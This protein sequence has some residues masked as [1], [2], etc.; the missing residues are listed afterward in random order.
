MGLMET[1]QL[2]GNFGEFVGAIAV[3]LTLIYLA[4]QVGQSKKSIDENTRALDEN[5][6]FTREDMERQLVR[7]WDQTNY[8]LVEN[9]D[10]ASIVVRGY[11]DLES[12]DD[13]ER[14]IFSLRFGSRLNLHYASMRLA[15]DG[16]IGEEYAGA[17]DAYLGLT[18]A[19]DGAKQ[20]WQE[21]EPGYPESFSKHVN[22][23]LAA[24]D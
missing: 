6:T 18:L 2:L 11:D 14:L 4:V 12:L 17:V 22:S 1:A 20:F 10:I 3:V 9:R 24:E 19:S 21:V 7:Q 13:E 8:W 5:R 23:F 15:R 16:F